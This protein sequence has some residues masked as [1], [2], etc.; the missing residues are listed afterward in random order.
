MKGRA[1]AGGEYVELIG[2]YD[3]MVWERRPTYTQKEFLNSIQRRSDKSSLAVLRSLPLLT[4][5]C[6][7]PFLPSEDLNLWS[8]LLLSLHNTYLFFNRDV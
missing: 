8:T 2:G 4:V 1:C 3:A 7:P 5:F 6:S